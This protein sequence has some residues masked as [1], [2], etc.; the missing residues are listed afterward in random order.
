MFRGVGFSTVVDGLCEDQG[1]SKYVFPSW[2]DG[3]GVERSAEDASE[4]Q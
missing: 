1:S 2:P 4:A 3:D